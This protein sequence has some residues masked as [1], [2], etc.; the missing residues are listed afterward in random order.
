MRRD[1]L[2][3]LD[4]VRAPSQWADL[5]SPSVALP[6]LVEAPIVLPDGMVLDPVDSR[7]VTAA[8]PGRP[9]SPADV[10]PRTDVWVANAS[11]WRQGVVVGGIERT[12]SGSN[13]TGNAGKVATVPVI[14][15]PDRTGRL[16]RHRF[17]VSEVRL[18]GVDDE[19]TPD[20][21]LDEDV[22]GFETLPIDCDPGPRPAAMPASGADVW[23]LAGR[24]WRHGVVTRRAHDSAVVA[25]RLASGLVGLR[26]ATPLADL[27]L[28][29]A[30]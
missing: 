14:Y 20:I 25:Y 3:L 9:A 27:R 2:A 8:P 13:H 18:R 22:L 28:R 19:P 16:D 23:V 21:V 1:P 26:Q 29:E 11:R 17:P 15:C 12:Q 30:S 24:R 6:R 4:S 5:V 10:P 7:P